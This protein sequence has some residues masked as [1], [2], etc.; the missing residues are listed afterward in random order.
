MLYMQ[1]LKFQ[2][3][4]HY[5]L[6]TNACKDLFDTPKHIWPPKISKDRRHIVFKIEIG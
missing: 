5:D 2:V 3:L 4:E 1:E 6:L